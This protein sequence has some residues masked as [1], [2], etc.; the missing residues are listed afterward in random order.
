VLDEQN[1]SGVT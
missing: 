1:N